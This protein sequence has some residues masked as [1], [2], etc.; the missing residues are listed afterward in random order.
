MVLMFWLAVA[1]SVLPLRGGPLAGRILADDGMPLPESA[2]VALDCGTAVL[3]PVG[4]DAAGGFTI[5]DAPDLT[6]CAL[7]AA[8]PGYRDSSIPADSLP[9]VA[10]IPAAV[11]YRLGKN[12]GESISA[13]HLAAPSAAVEHY[14]AAVREMRRG[15]QA[16]IEAALAHC[17]EAVLAYP[18]YAQAWFEIGRLQLAR[19]DYGKAVNALRRAVEADPWFVSPYEPLILLF[20]ATGS[21]AEAASACQGL[22]RINPDLPAGCPER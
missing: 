22:R 12:D 2:Q 13:S 17:Q 8:A 18:D 15:A 20:R 6:D 10:R 1:V 3:G 14:H 5:P 21:A 11:L 16:D 7:R 9:R 4:L 19:G